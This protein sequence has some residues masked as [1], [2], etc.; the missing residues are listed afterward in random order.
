[1]GKKKLNEGKCP[2]KIGDSVK[3]IPSERFKCWHQESF[4]RLN[5]YPGYIGK[6]TKIEKDTFI[7]LD[8]NKGGF[9]WIEFKKQKE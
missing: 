8:G 7:Y 5:I 6:V 2:F 3:F 4:Y 1:M 9:H